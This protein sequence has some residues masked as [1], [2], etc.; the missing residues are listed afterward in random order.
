LCILVVIKNPERNAEAIARGGNR[1]DGQMILEVPRQ[2]EKISKE[3]LEYAAKRNITIR[4][5]KSL[6]F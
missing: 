1:L 3:V 2:T 5:I 6:Y 4:D